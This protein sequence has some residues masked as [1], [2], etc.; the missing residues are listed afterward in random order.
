MTWHAGMVWKVTRPN[1]AGCPPLGLCEECFMSRDNSDLE[2]LWHC[3]TDNGSS[4]QKC[5]QEQVEGVGLRY[6]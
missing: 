2:T 6:L 1:C 4:D 3:I 5:A